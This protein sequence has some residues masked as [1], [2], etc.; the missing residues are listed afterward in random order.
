MQGE[1]LKADDFR[2]QMK[3][4]VDTLD[5]HL[6]LLRLPSYYESPRFHSSIAWVTLPV[7]S[8]G[9]G[10]PFDESTLAKL[11][12]RF[13]KRLREEKIWVGELV[14]KIGK[15]VQRFPFA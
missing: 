13:G 9:G 5:P 2:S 8:S 1:D 12:E 4:I 11:E 7:A 6:Q 14:C 15:E 3:E 10:I